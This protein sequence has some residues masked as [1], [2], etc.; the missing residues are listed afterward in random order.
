MPWVPDGGTSNSQPIVSFHSISSKP[1]PGG[2]ASTVVVQSGTVEQAVEEA[3]KAIKSIPT[4]PALA[5]LPAN[6][7]PGQLYS[8]ASQPGTLYFQGA[9]NVWRALLAVAVQ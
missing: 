6:A 7:V 8:F 3:S 5:N 2:V 4:A 9:D 1:I